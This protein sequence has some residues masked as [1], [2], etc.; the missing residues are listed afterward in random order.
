MEP[1]ASA[2][3]VTVREFRE[4]LLWPLQLEPL[5]QGIQIQKHWEI[6]A[7]LPGGSVWKEVEDEFTDG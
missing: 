2:A 3:S 7:S 6:L 5:K 4:I 1:K